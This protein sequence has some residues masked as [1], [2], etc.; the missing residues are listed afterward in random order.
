MNFFRNNKTILKYSLLVLFVIWCLGFIFRSSI[1]GIDGNRYYCLFDDAMIS[2]RYAW[3]LS[4]GN[5][6]VWNQGI[7]VEGYSNLL[8]TLIMAIS[9]FFFNKI[10]AVLIVQILGIIFLVCIGLVSVKINEIIYN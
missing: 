2:M 8:M 3:N 6:L 10:H 5:G 4:H 9:T 7:K 1:I